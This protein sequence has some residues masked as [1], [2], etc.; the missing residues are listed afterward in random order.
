MV[1]EYDVFLSHN[2]AYDSTVLERIADRL[3][4]YGLEPWLNAWA[5]TP[6]GAWQREL[7][8]WAFRDTATNTQLYTAALPVLRDTF[9]V[10]RVALVLDDGQ[11]GI[12]SAADAVR[13]AAGSAG[14]RV[15]GTG[16]HIA[17]DELDLRQEVGAIAQG[18]RT[19]HVDGLV[20]LSGPVEVGLLARAMATAGVAIPVLGHPAQNSQS[21]FDT[22]GS[23][24]SRWL[25]P[26]VFSPY[27][28]ARAI[29]F[30]TV[31][32][33]RGGVHVAPEAANYY[34]MVHAIAQVARAAGITATTDLTTARAAIRKGLSNLSYQGMMGTTSFCPTGDTQKPVFTVLA[35][36]AASLFLTVDPQPVPCP[37]A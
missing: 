12:E 30:A 21:Y 22:G 17:P 18:V 15:V 8:T 29:R 35:G 3:K 31:L 19:H 2:G 33:Q 25:L 27:Q 26:S 7:G 1:D 20:V 32:S 16:I 9:S 34:D 14:V 23:A 11:P 36:S 37:G 13:S 24:I 4:R 6:G 10:R 28:N 5:L